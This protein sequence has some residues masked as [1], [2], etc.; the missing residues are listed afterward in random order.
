MSDHN[1]LDDLRAFARDNVAR[2]QERHCDAPSTITV[3][4]DVTGGLLR[5][6]CD[7]CAGQHMFDGRVVNDLADAERTRRMIR[8]KVLK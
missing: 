7:G 8:A 4:D 1:I 2:C 3:L 6:V 5:R